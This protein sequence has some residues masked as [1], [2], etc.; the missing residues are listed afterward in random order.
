MKV[1]TIECKW[2]TEMVQLMYLQITK[3]NYKFSMKNEMMNKDNYKNFKD[4]HNKDLTNYFDIRLYEK[5]EINSELDNIQSNFLSYIRLFDLNEKN[6]S[7]TFTKDNC[8]MSLIN[9]YFKKIS[10]NEILFNSVCR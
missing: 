7:L 5:K 4:I 10:A 6:D 1:F 2:L 9:L 8:D 3:K